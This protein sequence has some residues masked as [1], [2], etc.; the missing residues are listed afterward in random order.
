MRRAEFGFA[1]LLAVTLFGKVAFAQ[2]GSDSDQP[3]F[4]ESI[5]A[6]LR[7]S[8][9]ETR[10]E[11]RP[12]GSVVGARLGGCRMIVREYVAQGTFAATILDQARS[13]G[14]VRYMYRGESYSKPPKLRPLGELYLRRLRQRVSDSVARAPII[15]VAASPECATAT[16]PWDKVAVLPS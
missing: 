3:L 4:A 13:V 5:A 16:L 12:L 10:I 11:A 7:S 1:A 9:F 6:M 15:A 14:P 8:G 2:P